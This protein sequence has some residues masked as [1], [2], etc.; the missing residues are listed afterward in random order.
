MTLMLT[1]IH[2]QT[3]TVGNTEKQTN[4]HKYMYTKTDTKQ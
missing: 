4:R 3:H 2:T 1:F